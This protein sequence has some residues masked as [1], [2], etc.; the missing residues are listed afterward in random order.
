MA[1]AVGGY[2]RSQKRR[3]KKFLGDGLKPPLARHK[4]QD[5]CRRERISRTDG[6]REGGP[7]YVV[8]HITTIGLNASRYWCDAIFPS[9]ALSLRQL[10]PG[11][12]V[13]EPAIGQGFSKPSRGGLSSLPAPEPGSRICPG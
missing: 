9:P 8:H 4:N 1:W 5:R 6:T 11:W 13:A 12:C 7:R 2:R 10:D 3:R